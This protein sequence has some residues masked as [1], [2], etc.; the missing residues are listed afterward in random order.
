MA[1]VI[2]PVY[3]ELDDQELSYKRPLTE[4]TVRK[5]VQNVNM[6]G[7]LALIGSVRA[8]A[9]NTPGVPQVPV[10][11][12]QYCDGS[13]IT[14]VNSPLQATSGHPRAVPNLADKYIRGAA[15][16]T[17]NTDTGDLTAGGSRTR[18]LSHTHTTGAVNNGSILATDGTERHGYGSPDH[19]HGVSTDLSDS[20]PIELAH[21]QTA[22]YLKIN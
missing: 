8:I 2:P 11:Q 16:T 15:D 9:V 13:Q 6:L 20:D 22:Y 1:V 21:V 12:F 17:S 19:N 5:L 18:D 3:T 7:S 14:D 10:S 4:E